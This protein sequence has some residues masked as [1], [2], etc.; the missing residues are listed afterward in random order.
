MLEFL[1]KI[2]IP[3]TAAAAITAI[4]TVVPFLWKIDERYAKQ[5]QLEEIIKKLESQNNELSRELSQSIGF[6]QAMI[7]LIQ[8]GKT[9]PIEV[10]KSIKNPT[11]A[12]PKDNKPV[13]P[14]TKNIHVQVQSP[15]A[16]VGEELKNWDGISKGLIR[17]Q[18][19]LQQQIIIKP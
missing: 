18:G 10:I 8:Q 13:V 7:L 3:A 5:D 6:Q 9:P 14:V 16:I 19:R 4:I 11:I 2:G 17:Q 1:K 12:L 15:D